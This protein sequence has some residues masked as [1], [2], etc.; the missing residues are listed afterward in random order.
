MGH[1]GGNDNSV[2][3]DETVILLSVLLNTCD[4]ISFTDYR[5]SV[6][7]NFL[8]LSSNKENWASGRQSLVNVS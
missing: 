6:L 4:Y 2:S 8:H 7:L 1:R 5:F 3:Q